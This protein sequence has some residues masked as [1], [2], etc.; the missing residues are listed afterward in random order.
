MVVCLVGV[1]VQQVF[2]HASNGSVDAHVVVVEHDE[3]VVV[4]RRHVVNALESQSATHS[5]VADY[6]HNVALLVA[7]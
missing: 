3:Q 7:A 6:G 4:R 5:S 2:L 1:E